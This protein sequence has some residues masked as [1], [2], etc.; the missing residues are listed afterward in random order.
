M[1][2]SNSYNTFTK[3]QFNF[4]LF[5]L[6]FNFFFFVIMDVFYIKALC[7]R[8]D[9]ID[10]D[11][12]KTLENKIKALFHIAHSHMRNNNFSFDD[13]WLNIASTFTYYFLS[14]RTTTIGEE[15]IGI[16]IT[17][18]KSFIFYFF[19]LAFKKLFSVI[20]EKLYEKLK[21]YFTNKRCSKLY[22]DLLDTLLPSLNTIENMYN[23]FFLLNNTANISIIQRLIG[24]KYEMKNLRK[25]FSETNKYV[26]KI[27]GLIS[28]TRLLMK[29]I[30]TL[31]FSYRLIYINGKNKNEDL[32]LKLSLNPTDTRKYCPLCLSKYKSRSLTPCGHSFCWDC[33]IKYIVTK[34]VLMCPKCRYKIRP[35]EIILLQNYE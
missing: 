29:L 33:I 6:Y 21:K 18:N 13:Y 31:K 20:F 5:F 23:C 8:R 28:L 24:I 19:Y 26:I 17:R 2:Y 3:I 16:K 10:S 9:F 4:D 32:K 7:L 34:K 14:F 22:S 25:P 11:I 12:I 35:N 27:I 30:N 1:R 15:Y